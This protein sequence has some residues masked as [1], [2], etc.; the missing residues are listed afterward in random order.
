VQ[1]AAAELTPEM[2]AQ[3]DPAPNVAPAPDDL[4]ENED[5]QITQAIRDQ[6]AALHH[7]PVEIYS[8]VRNSVEF[9][10]TYGSIQGSDV[11]L[12]TKRGNAFDTASLLI[13]L[14]RASSIPARYAYGTIRVPADQVMNWV[15]GVKTPEAAQSLLGQGGIP[16]VALVSGG[17]ITA[18]KLEHVWVEAFVDFIPSRGAIHRTGDT[19]VPL[20]ASFKQYTYKDGM[21]L[22]NAVPFDVQS[23]IDQIQTGATV[24]EAEGWVQNID[25][26]LIQQ[27]L[28]D[29]QSQIKTYIDGQKP[30]ATVGDVIG[31]KRIAE[32]KSPFL[33]GTL[34]YMLLVSGPKTA[35]L[36]NALRH[37]VRL[38]LYGSSLDRS[39]DSPAVTYSASL[40]SLAGK[41]LS[42]TYDPASSADQAVIDDAVANYRNSLPAYLIQ[43]KPVLKA[44]G[45]VLASGGSYAMGE[46][47]ILSV[48]IIAPWYQHNRD[49][50]VTAGDFFALGLNPAGITADLFNARTHQHDLNNTTGPDFA[51]YMAEMFH[52]IALAWWAEKFAFNDIIGITNRVIHYQLPSHVLAGS[53]LNVRYFFGIPRSASYGSRVMDAKEDLIMA[54]PAD[55]NAESQRRFVLAAGY[56]GSYLE[57][58]IFDQAFLLDPGHSMSTITALKAAN[59]RGVAIYTIDQ[60]NVAALAQI[61]TDPEDLQDMQN[62]VAAGLRVTTAQHDIT[63]DN[64]TGLGYILEDPETGAAAYLISG[65]RNGGNSPSGQFVYPMPQ[66]V[67]TPIHNFMLSFTLRNAG[68][69]LAFQNGIVSGIVLP[70]TAASTTVTGGSVA[71]GAFGSLSA[72]IITALVIYSSHAQ[73]IEN[74]YP[75]TSRVLRHFTRAIHGPLIWASKMIISSKE[76]GTFNKDFRAVYMAD[77]N[78]PQ[79]RAS[80]PPTA[81]NS[82]QISID[83]E[84]PLEKNETIE[85]RVRAYVDI[86][87][88]REGYWDSVIIDERTTI[89]SQGTHEVV[90]KLPLLYFGPF[91][92]GIYGLGACY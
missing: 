9:L 63:V 4:A 1:V 53:P 72:A 82:R 62:A 40:P 23:L 7:N 20:D 28:T 13:A 71:G 29:Y 57:A 61:Q 64:F 31:T 22:K 11:T 42:F 47:H 51:A 26:N 46:K 45:E 36:S 85:E 87:I 41:R 33:A 55:G 86:E 58:G 68:A 18:F 70:E 91:S 6:A 35:V 15:G 73:E 88:T 10:P 80:C 69:S 67:A 75:K 3:A 78:D 17:K 66:P 27:A 19:W 43:V 37:K 81:D 25:Q 30:E 38:T 76:G 49:Y 39:L 89:N 2:L 77:I 90:F 5:V 48:D 79:A 24:N 74:R 32:Q 84:L 60:N 21:D 8:W 14:L 12:Q 92:I 44:E 50:Q 34:P 56:V 52:Q 16:N 54:A 83:Y 65:G 59:E